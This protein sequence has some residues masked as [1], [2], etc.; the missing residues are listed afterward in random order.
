MLVFLKS[1][2]PPYL[3]ALVQVVAGSQGDGSAEFMQ[4]AVEERE[5]MRRELEAER[6]QHEAAKKAIADLQKAVRARNTH[7]LEQS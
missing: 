3:S 7:L 4:L 1:W 2:H 6:V 5:S